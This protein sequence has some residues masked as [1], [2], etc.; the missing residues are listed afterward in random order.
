MGSS[1][2]SQYCPINSLKVTVLRIVAGRHSHRKRTFPV[3]VA[4]RRDAIGTIPGIVVRICGTAENVSQLV[5]MLKPGTI[6]Q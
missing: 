2:V 6:N 5:I 1:S 3:G 4:S